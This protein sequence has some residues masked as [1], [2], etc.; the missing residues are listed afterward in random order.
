MT[1]HLEKIEK[2][3]P[4][5]WFIEWEVEF[6]TWNKARH[7]QN[8]GK[9]VHWRPGH[10]PLVRRSP[11]SALPLGLANVASTWLQGQS[12]WHATAQENLGLIEKCWMRTHACPKSILSSPLTRDLDGFE[13]LPANVFWVSVGFKPVSRVKSL[14]TSIRRFGYGLP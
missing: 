13:S 10:N 7:S 12:D 11:P 3:L 2:I 6:L 9:S 8:L 5:R 1:W 4:R 14:T